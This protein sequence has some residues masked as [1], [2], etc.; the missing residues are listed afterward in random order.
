MLVVV[1][2]MAPDEIS[3]QQGRRRQVVHAADGGQHMPG[4]RQ[5]R[6]RGMHAF[7]HPIQALANLIDFRKIPPA[8]QTAL[9]RRATVQAQA[10]IRIQLL[11]RTMGRRN[12]AAMAIEKIKVLKEKAPS[13]PVM[14]DGFA[15][16]DMQEVV[17]RDRQM[18][19][20]DG[21]FVIIASVNSSNGKLKKSP[22]IISR[23]FIYLKENQ[24][25]LHQVRLIIKKTIEDGAMGMNPM[26][27]DS[28]KTELGDNISKFLF[29]KTAKR[30]IVIPV[31]VGV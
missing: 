31:L 19:A 17:L 20:Q 26:N 14:V 24:E 6:G 12:I 28:I 15:V 4:D 11:K 16:G 22:D 18:L 29:Q 30:P 8:A 9:D 13:T 5:L 1:A 23:G 10:L 27:F 2:A 25:L 7:S 3:A 21:M